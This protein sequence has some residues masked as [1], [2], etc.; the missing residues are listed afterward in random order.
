MTSVN[1]E[2]VRISSESNSNYVDVKFNY[3]IHYKD[4][5]GKAQTADGNYWDG[6]AI[7]NIDGKW[8]Q[9]DLCADTLTYLWSW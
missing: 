5:D 8:V 7:T 2:N 3:I 4:A 9:S 1:F 6:T